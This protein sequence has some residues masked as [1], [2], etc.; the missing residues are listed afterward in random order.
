MAPACTVE[1]Y[2][3]HYRTRLGSSAAAPTRLR[4]L[5]IYSLTDEQERDDT[6]TPMYRKSLLYLV[7]NAFEGDDSKPLLGMQKFNR[8]LRRDTWPRVFYSGQ[9]SPPHTRSKVHGGFDNDVTTINDIL[10]AI[11][12]P[13]RIVRPFTKK[14][15]KY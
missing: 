13:T 1:L 12:G 11:L 14:D 9:G 3:T 8:R 10:K 15:L 2:R 5:N 6:V 4:K 7:S